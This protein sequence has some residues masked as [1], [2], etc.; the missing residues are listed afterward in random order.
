MKQHWSE[1]AATAEPGRA[2]RGTVPARSEAQPGATR[3]PILQL[4]ATIGNQAVNRL[5]QSGK[6]QTKRT[7][8]R[9]GDRPVQRQESDEEE[10][11]QSPGDALQK[12]PGPFTAPPAQHPNRTGLPDHLKA[13]IESLSGFSMDD[14]RVYYNSSQ[15]AQ[16]NALA[17]TQGTEIHVAPGQEQHLPHEAWHVVQQAQR[18][19]QPTMQLKDSVPVNDDAGLEREAE[20]MGARAVQ[21]CILQQDSPRAR[22]EQAAAGLPIQRQVLANITVGDNL[23]APITDVIIGGRTPSPFASTMGA[24]S[25]AWVAHVDQVRRVLI[26]RDLVSAATSLCGLATAEINSELLTLQD[27]V[28]SNQKAA[29]TT[30]QAT[31][32]THIQALTQKLQGGDASAILAGIRRLIDSYLTFVNYLPSATVM[33]GDP[34]GHGEGSARSRLNTFEYLY[35]KIHGSAKVTPEITD[36]I[37][38][39]GNDDFGR[40]LRREANQA[41]A[42]ASDTLARELSRNLWLLFAAETPGVFAK[43]QD[44]NDKLEV[45]KTMVKNFLST[46]RS[47]YP[48]AY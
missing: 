12:Q 34:S 3:H 8:S 6:L 18:R 24:H 15:P 14:V 16:L 42:N 28:D 25:T 23:N 41:F 35:S 20:M 21:R 44:D 47:A 48:Y 1:K 37:T 38:A 5:L 19:V 39:V 31:M 2:R 36:A 10:L 29:I 46:I 30:A 45:W 33:G 9:P 26:G 27:L 7:V 32:S 13:G 22:P 40:A 17:Y 43:D 11:F 4:Q